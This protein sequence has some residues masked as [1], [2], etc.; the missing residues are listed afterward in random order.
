MV[1]CLGM[2][3]LVGLEPST[4]ASQFPGDPNSSPKGME[5][6]A[7][8]WLGYIGDEILSRYI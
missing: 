4:V 5:K 2:G 8:G 3:F 7:P 6:R 1:G